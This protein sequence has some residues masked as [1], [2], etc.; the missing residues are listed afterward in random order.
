MAQR[1]SKTNSKKILKR[2]KEKLCTLVQYGCMCENEKERE[3]RE[4]ER[5]RKKEKIER[6]NKQIALLLEACS[7]INSYPAT[8]AHNDLQSTVV[9]AYCDHVYCN[10][11]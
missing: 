7:H 3:N 4:R 6:K 8:K 9:A 2:K 10:H 5:K 1:N 11:S